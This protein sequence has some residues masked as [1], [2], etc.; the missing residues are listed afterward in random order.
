MEKNTQISA[1]VIRGDSYELSRYYKSDLPTG[2]TKVCSSKTHIYLCGKSQNKS[3]CN[4]SPVQCIKKLI[5]PW[6]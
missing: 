6:F 2:E 4:E 5:N 3:F 1:N